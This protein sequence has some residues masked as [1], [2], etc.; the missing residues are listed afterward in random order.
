MAGEPEHTESDEETLAA[1]QAGPSASGPLLFRRYRVVRELG[2]GGM[3][4]VMLAQDSALDVL[5]AVK[6]VPDTVVKD[7][8]SVADLR[9]EVLRGM[10]LA[11]PGI[12]RTHHFERDESGAGIIMEYVD[13]ETLTD[14]KQKQ[15]GGCFNPEQILPWIEQL[16]AVLDYAHGDA[17]I[18]HR[19]LKPRNIML[20]QNGRIK[21]ADFGIAAILSDSMSRHSMEGRV[22]GTLSYMS[23]Q[24]VEGK[25]PSHLDDIHALGATVY[26]LLTSRP[27]FFRGNQ[28]SIF[29][30]VLAVTPPS[31]MER[32]EE[33]Q[34]TGK[35]PIPKLW[36]AA[37]AA[38]LAKDPTRRPQ[39]AGE[40]ARML[41][42]GLHGAP[43][44]ARSHTGA[45]AKW[46]G[47]TPWLVGSA[48]VVLAGLVAVTVLI[49]GGSERWR[50]ENPTE[51]VPAT[52]SPL[53]T[54]ST[55]TPVPDSPSAPV[56]A[57]TPVA[58][59][60]ATP[61]PAMAQAGPSEP[62]DSWSR[63]AGTYQGPCSTTVNF[64]QG[65]NPFRSQGDATLTVAGTRAA[66]VVSAVFEMHDSL[67]NAATQIYSTA[68]GGKARVEGESVILAGGY[69]FGASTRN[70][71]LQIRF[72]DGRAAVSIRD[73]N[74]YD[75]SSGSFTLEKQK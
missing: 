17:H 14:L 40:V 5:V 59:P 21:V 15:P 74:I 30:Q 62:A 19:D 47:R 64:K 7:T 61:A 8:E 22:S 43:A 44:P 36:E 4:V 10:A 68:T 71:E 75:E 72:T 50:T 45:A 27:P 49:F 41:R 69:R 60:Q 18:V 34:V 51:V 73:S 63:Y 46:R 66:P 28:A 16:C 58:V 6:L 1:K 53:V 38:C 23:P 39:S 3:G 31:M 2:R 12:V 26:E 54:S 32:R 35:P 33:L 56:S 20:T 11:H 9:K 57:L 24:Q 42:A 13:G 52:P 67:G 55:A 37:V 70:Y 48:A 65:L 25:R 29:Q